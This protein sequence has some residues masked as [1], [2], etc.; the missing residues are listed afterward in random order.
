[1]KYSQY[2]LLKNGLK[3][4]P[5]LTTM[6]G[7]LT[8][9]LMSAA[10]DVN[11]DAARV[12]QQFAWD[13]ALGGVL[14]LLGGFAIS[15]FGQA[16]LERVDVVDDPRYKDKRGADG[17]QIIRSKVIKVYEKADL[18]DHKKSIAKMMSKY[19]EKAD[20]EK[21][22]RTQ[23][24]EIGTKGLEEKRKA[25]LGIKSSTTNKSGVNKSGI[26]KSGARK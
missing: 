11:F 23:I 26:N 18:E 21:V 22:E 20:A 8:G 4:F 7:G 16:A 25:A 2:T 1:M 12:G 15:G 9:Y 17:S 3:A 13:V 5:L 19:K 24:L 6:V 14:G 10:H